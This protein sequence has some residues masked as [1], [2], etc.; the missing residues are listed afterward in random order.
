MERFCRPADHF[1]SVITWPL[2]F[3]LVLLLPWPSIIGLSIIGLEIMLRIALHY[4]VRQSFRMN[5]P[6]R[7]WLIPLRECVCFFAWAFGLFGNKVRWGK[8][9]FTYEAF[10]KL[11][12]D[13]RNVGS[14]GHERQATSLGDKR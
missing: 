1:M 9:I 14:N 10:R 6:P 11:I 13:G 5:S 4:Q 3:L 2:P 8:N 12:A 7:P